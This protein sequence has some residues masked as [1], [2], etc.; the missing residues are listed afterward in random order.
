MCGVLLVIAMLISPKSGMVFRWLSHGKIARKILGEDVL[1][2]MYRR[3]E[4]S[5]GVA[6][7]SEQELVKQFKS[8]LKRIR[9]VLSDLIKLG[10]LRR[11]ASGVELTADGFK[12][13]QNVVRSHRLWEQYL[14]VE[15]NVSDARLHAQAES[16]EHFTDQSMRGQL[17]VQVGQ[18]SQDPH[19]RN[20]PPESQ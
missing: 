5:P 15:M 2:Y 17:D 7:Q 20:I 14:S 11:D 10:W 4:K 6:K 9:T 16:L 13:A 3:S 18:V 8:S 12:T 19:G 1:A